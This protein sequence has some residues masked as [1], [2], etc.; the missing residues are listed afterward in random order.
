MGY[1]TSEE[2]REWYNKY[3]YK[4]NNSDKLKQ[5][6]L[7]N[8]DKIKERDGKKHDCICGGKYTHG[9]IKRHENTKK[10]QKYITENN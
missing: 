6:Y 8:A 3:K 5:Y 10:H 9:N 2:R 1:K 7:D 4:I